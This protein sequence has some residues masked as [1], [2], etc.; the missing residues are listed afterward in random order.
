MA[1]VDVVECAILIRPRVLFREGM[2]Q[3]EL[4]EITRG[5]WV[6]GARRDCAELAFSVHRGVVRA[7]Y[8]PAGTDPS[9][10]HQGPPPPGRWEFVGQPASEEI[11]RAYVRRSVAHYFRRGNQNPILNVNC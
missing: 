6:V 7:V 9:T 4:Y 10:V 11:C 2:S 3:E 1:S 8:T 5:Y